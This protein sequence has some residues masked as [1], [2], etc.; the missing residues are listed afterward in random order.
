MNGN[1]AIE[2]RKVTNLNGS[3]RENGWFSGTYIDGK[4]MCRSGGTEGAGMIY[5]SAGRAQYCTLAMLHFRLN[6]NDI[7]VSMFNFA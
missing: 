6:L 3:L 2:K 1:C 7:A 5:R 4:Q